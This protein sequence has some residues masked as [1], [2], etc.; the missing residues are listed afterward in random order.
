MQ[1][2]CSVCRK[3]IVVMA[4]LNNTVCCENCLKVTKG[5]TPV[6]KATV[7]DEP[8]VLVDNTVNLGGIQ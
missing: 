1:N 4:F 7:V 5:E 8:I 2:Y 3:K 6:P